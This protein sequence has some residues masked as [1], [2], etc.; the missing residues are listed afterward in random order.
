MKL[1]HL[2]DNALRISS[3]KA[4]QNERTATSVVLHHLREVD[5]R[6]LYSKWKYPDLKSYAVGDLKYTE[7]E[8]WL[9]ISAMQFLKDLP[10]IEE[11]VNDGS[12]QLST[13]VLAKRAFAKEVKQLTETK[14]QFE[15]QAQSATALE[16]P[17]IQAKPLRTKEEK[18]RIIEKLENV[19]KREAIKIIE[20]ETGVSVKSQES[21]RPLSD[22]NFEMKTILNKDVLNRI[23]KAKGLLA[24][25]YPNIT[26]A[27]LLSLALEALMKEIDP[28]LKAKNALQKA[29]KEQSTDKSTVPEQ[30]SKHYIPAAVRHH[31]WTR[32]KGKCTNCGSGYA[33]QH[34]HIVPFA[35]GGENTI[36]NI[37][38]L[39]RSCNQRSAIESYGM[40]KMSLYLR[41][42]VTQYHLD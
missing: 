13:L 39:C 42:P 27:A 36:E 10:E 20:H 29:K 30:S 3:Q 24:H 21:I 15:L 2:N 1:N 37:K 7:D 18:L 11:K 33:V 25:S 19:S 9:R 5:R 26:N 12:L 8:A 41:A 17:S 40:K 34:E 28:A 22:G 14:P 16:V 35:K 38:L 6:R 23:E 31:V 32:D 4:A